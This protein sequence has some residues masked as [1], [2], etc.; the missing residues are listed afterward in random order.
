MSEPSI[1][2]SELM[3]MA[4]FTLG[5][6]IWCVSDDET[7]IPFLLSERDEKRELI[8]F[9]AE[10]LEDAVQEATDNLRENSG[11]WNRAA[12]VYDGYVTIDEL[13]TDALI[14]QAVEFGVTENPVRCLA[15]Q[16]ITSVV[17]GLELGRLLEFGG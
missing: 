14:A 15:H 5:H 9:T 13:R 17:K 11:C 7:L 2:L 12:V 4:G 10:Q 6:A 16:V 8:R 1:D 3:R